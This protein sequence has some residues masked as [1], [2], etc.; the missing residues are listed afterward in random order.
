MQQ[1]KSF[2]R[3]DFY[4]QKGYSSIPGGDFGLA[5]DT[6]C[7]SRICR[8]CK[9]LIFSTWTFPAPLFWILIGPFTSHA[10]TLN[11]ACRLRGISDWGTSKLF[12]F[13]C[14]AITIPFLLWQSGAMHSL[15]LWE[16]ME[17]V[18]EVRPQCQLEHTIHV[19]LS[20]L[21][22]MSVCIQVL[23]SATQINAMLKLLKGWMKMGRRRRCRRMR[24]TSNYF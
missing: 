13:H 18:K 3:R 23:K 17:T 1:W 16:E 7:P 6:A 20:G 24:T 15:S 22:H 2:Q 11:P 21:T 8:W 4:K 19:V 12:S 10:G 14:F 5:E 9:S